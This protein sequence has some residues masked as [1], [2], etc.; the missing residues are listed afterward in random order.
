MK[1]KKTIIPLLFCFVLLVGLAA[2]LL[3]AHATG[4]FTDARTIYKNTAVQ[5]KDVTTGASSAEGIY[6]SL[7]W[8]NHADDI[9][10]VAYAN[11]STFVGW[12]EVYG[13]TVTSVSNSSTYDAG[14]PVIDA[15]YRAEFTGAGGYNTF[16]LQAVL[17]SSPDSC[18]IFDE[19]TGIQSITSPDE[20]IFSFNPGDKLLFTVDFQP[21]DVYIYSQVFFYNTNTTL[22]EYYS[23]FVLTNVTSSLVVYTYFTGQI[24]G[25]TPT[26]SPTP[27]GLTF[28]PTGFKSDFTAIIEMIVGMLLTA[29][30]VLVLTK[31]SSAWVVGVIVLLA[32]F[33]TLIVSEPNLFGL[34]SFA[35]SVTIFGVFFY[36]GTSKT[37]K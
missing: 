19:T 16:P 28:N 18:S 15:E 34:A 2:C 23:P 17:I 32:G 29:A 22:T 10:Y 12:D 35:L 37:Q 20:T 26:P 25:P 24:I 4:F 1:S 21:F 5:I 6:E 7:T 31:A 9:Q 27:S 33:F 36:S 13:S 8:T 14:V 3:P 30:G 11:G